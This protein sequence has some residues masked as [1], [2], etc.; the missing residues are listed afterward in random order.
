MRFLP[1]N[2][3]WFCIRGRR[4]CVNLSDG[5]F[6]LY[7]MTRDRTELND[8][9]KSKPQQLQKMVAIWDQLSGEIGE[10]KKDKSKPKKN[11]SKK[12]ESKSAPAKSG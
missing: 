4:D 6:E 3:A 9:S 11:K 2:K 10:L 7:D 8:V 1:P 5:E 12:N